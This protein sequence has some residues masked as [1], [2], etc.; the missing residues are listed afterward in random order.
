MKLKRIL[1]ALVAASA[2]ATSA[3][4]FTPYGPQTAPLED[5]IQEDTTEGSSQAEST[6]PSG[7]VQQYRPKDYEYRMFEQILDAYVEKHLYEF[8]EGD[9]LHKFFED[10]LNDNPIYFSY[11][12]EYLLGTMDPY[13]SYYDASSN[14]LEPG[15][16]S[17]G[18]GFTIIDREDGVFI[19]SV[20]PNSNAMEAGFMAGDKFVSVAGI[21]VENQTFDVIST[22]LAK[23]QNFIKQEE[24]QEATEI[25]KTEEVTETTETAEAV[26]AT[27]TAEATDAAQAKE[28]TAHP[29]VEIVIDRNGEKHTFNLSRGPMEISQISSMVD[30]ND[31]KPTAYIQVS[32]FLGDETDTK[33]AQLVK[34]YADDGIKHLTIDLRDNGGGSLDYA[35]AMAEVFVENGE[36]ISYYKDRTLKEPQP[37]YS[38][39][40]KISFD[41]ITILINE[42]TASAAELFTSIL[43]DKGIA[44]VIGAKSYG[45]SLGQEVYTLAN[46]DYI[47]ITTYQML[48]ESLES[49]DG[50]GIIPDIA[51]EEVEMCYTL[52]SLGVFNH[53]NYVEIKEGEYSDV[54][55]AL[56]DRMVIM[57]ILREQYCDGIFD[58]TTKNALYVLQ[59]DHE[60]NATGYVDYETVSLI[61]RI[62]NSYKAST[63]YDSTQYDVAMIVHHSFSQGKRLANEKERLREEQAQLIEERDAA[64]DAA[65]EA[66]LEKET[67]QENIQEN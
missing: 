61:T 26:E 29:V 32:S 43:H 60:K 64:L 66:S 49:Y 53:Q 51:I 67:A 24:T 17:V 20:L 41:S 45:K 46:G 13:S 47:T 62:I 57:G 30:E 8:T 40:E 42:H 12:M 21:N 28:T 65:Y 6:F 58:E 48:N 38:T 55:K 44:K 2:F 54:T 1:A 18:F 59:K 23:P 39:T 15:K 16:G 19:E 5:E 33:F 31:G 50:I 63:Y 3:F 56:E 11:F 35:L 22:I 4:A 37:I 10:F 52:P 34:K 25:E 27:D 7:I 14:F 36:V 9:V